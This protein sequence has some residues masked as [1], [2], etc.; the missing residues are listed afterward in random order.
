MSEPGLQNQGGLSQI[1]ANLMIR[2]A[3]KD[4][5][6]RAG[7]IRPADAPGSQHEPIAAEV[8]NIAPPKPDAPSPQ[9]EKPIDLE[10]QIRALVTL[11]DADAKPNFSPLNVMLR[12]L[13]ALTLNLKSFGY[14]LA[15]A[16]AEQRPQYADL[17]AAKVGL[18]CKPSTQDDIESAWVAYWMSRLKAPVVYHRKIWELCY[19]LQALYD[20]DLLR[21]GA[22]G[23]GFGCGH[24]PLPSLM[25]SEG[26]EV[27]VTDLPPD[28]ERAKAWADTAQ[29]ASLTRSFRSDLVS[30]EDFD[31]HVALRHIDMNAIPPD[32]QGYDFCW[33]ICALEHLGS[34]AQG[35]NFIENS[36]QCLRPGGLAVH[37]TEFN[38]TDDGEIIDHWPTVLFRRKHFIELAERLRGQG[39]RVAELDFALGDKPLDRF[40]D[41]PPWSFEAPPHLR[42]YYEPVAQAHLKLSIDGFPC[43]CFGLIVQKGPAVA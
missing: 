2:I 10:A 20:H 11:V 26:V 41:L 24:E 14:E 13:P 18:C 19:V 30:R 40:I 22:R 27:L 8:S 43:T 34:I 17:S 12:D 6:A 32:L 3:G 28:D 7:S 16:L 15:R 9:L 36:L 38:F 4:R 21:P 39:H 29:H 1:I 37:T 5:L 35:L 25:A 33:S 23:V 42:G 31:R